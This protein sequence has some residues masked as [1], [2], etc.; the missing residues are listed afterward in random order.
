MR[1][2]P[3]GDMG[4]GYGQ[5][6]MMNMGMMGMPPMSYVSRVSSPAHSRSI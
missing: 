6:P 4:M 5:Y 3:P 2:Y 1:Q